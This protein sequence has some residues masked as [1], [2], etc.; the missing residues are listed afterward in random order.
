MSNSEKKPTQAELD[1]RSRQLNP[2]DV[3]HDLS[4]LDALPAEK[5]EATKE[6]LRKKL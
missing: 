5:V 2:K 6:E 3:V 1:N 4:R